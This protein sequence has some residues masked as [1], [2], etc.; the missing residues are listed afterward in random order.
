[1]YCGNSTGG[2]D[3]GADIDPDD[4]DSVYCEACGC[5][6][7]PALAVLD[8]DQ[9]VCAG[10]APCTVAEFER[11]EQAAAD[12]ELD[13]REAA[14]A[15][16]CDCFALGIEQPE[17]MARGTSCDRHAAELAELALRAKAVLLDEQAERDALK[18][19]P[20]CQERPDALNR[21]GCDYD[22]DA[23]S[24]VGLCAGSRVEVLFGP[25]R[26]K[27][28]TITES[29]G[30]TGYYAVALDEP[31]TSWPV[32]YFLPSEVAPTLV[33]PPVERSWA[34]DGAY[35]ALG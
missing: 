1:M 33:P 18:V 28:G 12:A 4:D 31:H 27:F 5:E 30:A 20:S 15:A 8:G 10:C 29:L 24:R 17:C 3:G 2:L 16:R 32:L 34:N 14:L 22:P 11:R 9:M 35:S 23:P 7:D 25:D 6:V 19:C 26:G 21:C 13:A